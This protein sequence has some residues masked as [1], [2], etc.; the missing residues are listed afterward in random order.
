MLRNDRYNIISIFDLFNYF[1]AKKLAHVILLNYRLYGLQNFNFPYLIVFYINRKTP[2]CGAFFFFTI[3]M[4]NL[5]TLKKKKLEQP[6]LL[7]PLMQII[8]L[9]NLRLVFHELPQLLFVLDIL[10]RFQYVL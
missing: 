9:R 10:I 7:Q 6:R 2:T 8:F 1:I 5:Y 3:Y 4:Q